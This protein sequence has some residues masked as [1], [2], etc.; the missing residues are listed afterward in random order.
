MKIVP[1]NSQ[2]VG[3]CN[4]PSMKAKKWF[5]TNL[6]GKTGPCQKSERERVKDV[7]ELTGEEKK[8]GEGNWVETR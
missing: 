3:T 4:S 5:K 8:E 2:L 1:Y 6:W 7:V